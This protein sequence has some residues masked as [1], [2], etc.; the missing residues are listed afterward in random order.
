[1]SDSNRRAFLKHTAAWASTGAIKAAG[2]NERLT[3]G[4]IGCGGRGSGLAREFAQLADIA[5]VC[6][7]D[8]S[9]RR[10]AREKVNAKHAVADLRRVLDDKSVD[11]IVVATPEHW[12]APAAILACEAGKHVYVEKPCSHNLREGR[13]MIEAARR[14]KRVMQVG[15]QSRSELFI[16]GAIQMLREG[17]IGD[18]LVA[19]AWDVQRRSNIGRQQPSDP[20]PGVDYDMWVGPAEFVPFQANRFHYHWHWWYNFGA[21]GIGGDGPHEVDYARWG[22]G[23]ETHPTTVA[24]LGGKFYFDDDQEFPDNGT[25]VFEWPGDGKVR[26]KRQLIFELRIWS[27]NYPLGVDSGAEYY[28]TKG[29]MFLSK[30]GKLEILDEKNKPVTAQPKNPPRLLPSHAADFLDAIK[31]GRTPNADIEVGHLSSSL[32]HLGNLAM[33]VGRSLHFDPRTEQIIGDKQANALLSRKYRKGGH[34]AIPRGV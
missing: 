22:L 1:M 6:D 30:R 24:G 23:V 26:H 27:P 2:A 29:K 32:V 16:A 4:I 34:W 10:Q 12:H 28:G 7:P 31:T 17:V 14:T 21:G 5:Y 3:L 20:P 15:T 33:R 25:V 9:R 8:E 13:L 19:K 18:V 11:A